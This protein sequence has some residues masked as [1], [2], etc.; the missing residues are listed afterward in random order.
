MKR[1]HQSFENVLA[2]TN[3][4]YLGLSFEEAAKR[5]RGNGKN[6]LKEERKTEKE[7]KGTRTNERVLY[8]SD[9]IDW[10]VA[11]RPR[12][13]ARIDPLRRFGTKRQ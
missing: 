2:H 4:K 7:N 10:S 1:C 8:Q 12:S 5:L 9:F 6:R 13:G 3:S 11:V